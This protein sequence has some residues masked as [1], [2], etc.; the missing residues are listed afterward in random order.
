MRR[1]IAR[2]AAGETTRYRE[3]LRSGPESF[4]TVDLQIAP[5]CDENGEICN[6]V[7]SALD[8]TQLAEAQTHQELLTGEL[9]HRVKNILA[10]VGALVSQTARRV[11]SKEELA[12][13]L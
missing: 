13:S 4:V 12:R 7:A 5:I 2:A 6:I 8:V 3:R 9:N 1:A 11:S 10:V